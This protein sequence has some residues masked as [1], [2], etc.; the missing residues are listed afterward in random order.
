M[1][2]CPAV[3][4]ED[5]SFSFGREPVLESVTCSIPEKDF[6]CMVG[7][8]GGGKTTLLKLIL[9]LL[10][11]TQGRIEVFGKSPVASRPRV[12]YMPQYAEL[13][14]HF[15]VNV[16]DVVLMGRLGP[17]R[18]FGPYRRADKAA[19]Q[20][21]IRQVGLEDARDHHLSSL[22]GGQR[23]RVLIA[24]ALAGEP[25]LLILDEPDAS[26]DPRV[27]VHLYDLLVQL[28]ERLTVIMVTHDIGVVSQAIKGVI[29]VNRHVSR[30]DTA[31]LTGEVISNL[32]GGDVQ[33]VSHDHGHGA[34]GHRHG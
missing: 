6:V 19:A 30:H 4:A 15:P 34:G 8:N 9:G 23:Q 11:P 13:D 2:S 22:S 16:M 33:M 18:R 14:P 21:A 10:K 1:D 26:L 12:G 27:Q 5:L 3:F 28:N 29:C 24:R 32:Y 7:P 31:E 17:G 20:E 25:D